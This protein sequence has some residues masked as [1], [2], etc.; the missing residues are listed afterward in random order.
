MISPTVT[1]FRTPRDPEKSGDCILSV[2][3]H[4]RKPRIG[5]S[6]KTKDHPNPHMHADYY[7]QP[8]VSLPLSR[9][10]HHKLTSTRSLQPSQRKFPK[11]TEVDHLSRIQLSIGPRLL[12]H[13][14]LCKQT[15]PVDEN[16]LQQQ[17]HLSPL[18]YSYH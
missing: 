15:V 1:L 3:K 2:L 9:K 18:P 12:R 13:R 4:T 14:T 6:N 11:T 8:V 10:V 16:P 7:R 5:H 17:L